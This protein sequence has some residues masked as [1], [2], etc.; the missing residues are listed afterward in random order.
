L[1]RVADQGAG[2]QAGSTVAVSMPKF[3]ITRGGRVV[4]VE[5]PDEA[6]AR[7]MSDYK[8][9]VATTAEA[10]DEAAAC[11]MADKVDVTTTVPAKNPNLTECPDCHH[12]VSKSAETCPSCGRKLK[13]TAADILAQLFA[14]A[15]LLIVCVV[16]LY[17]LW[18]LA[19][20]G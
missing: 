1:T 12:M 16:A 5:A 6:A 10:P 7:S 15:I 9:D 17:L 18:R 11:A 4:E 14:S 2:R 19:S 13:K 3:F 20:F 8:A